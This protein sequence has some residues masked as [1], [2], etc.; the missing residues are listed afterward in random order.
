MWEN[1]KVN[2]I[3]DEGSDDSGEW[4]QQETALD[5]NLPACQQRARAADIARF[6]RGG[7]RLENATRIYL[8]RKPSGVPDYVVL[9]GERLKV[10]DWDFRDKSQYWRLLVALQIK[11]ELS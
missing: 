2:L 5:I 9:D 6:E 11:S 4:I 7:E 8:K 10:F 1:C 3:K